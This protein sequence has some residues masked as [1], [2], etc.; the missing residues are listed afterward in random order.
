MNKQSQNREPVPMHPG[1]DDK[2]RLE[3]I[4]RT[5]RPGAS[6]DVLIGALG[7]DPSPP[8]DLA[9]RHDDY[10]RPLR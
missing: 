5:S 8:V 9:A 1:A 10:L 2:T 6:L 4:A 3:E 7:D